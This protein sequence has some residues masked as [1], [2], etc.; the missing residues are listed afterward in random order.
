MEHLEKETKLDG[1]GVDIVMFIGAR[2]VS[3]VACS[4]MFIFAT[5][6]VRSKGEIGWTVKHSNTLC[7]IFLVSFRVH[8]DPFVGIVSKTL[9][10]AQKAYSATG[11]RLFLV[12]I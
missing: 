5:L 8:I 11:L 1:D 12:L 10:R 4:Q 9:D 6:F 3:I 7:S 2:G